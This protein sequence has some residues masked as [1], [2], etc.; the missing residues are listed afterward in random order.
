M[1]VGISG[2]NDLL[3]EIT[4]DF[5]E[6][7]FSH[8]DIPVADLVFLILQGQWGPDRPDLAKVAR[9]LNLHPRTLQ[10]LLAREGLGFKD[11]VDRGRRE[12]TL[13]LITTTG[14]SF[15]QIAVQVGLREQSS[16]TRAVHR[17][18]DM[19]P[20]ELRSRRLPADRHRAS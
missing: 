5:L 14:L 15:S 2:G 3:R 12:Q 13:N 10:R 1:D 9:L 18:F 11:L 6:S 4:M 17:W 16:L 7:H 8:Q 19:S 20:S